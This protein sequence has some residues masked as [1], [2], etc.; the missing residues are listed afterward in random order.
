MDISKIPQLSGWRESPRFPLLYI[1]KNGRE[2]VWACWVKGNIVYRTDG[3]VDGKLKDPQ[4]HEYSGN[5]LRSGEEQA[6][7]EAEKLWLKQVDHD[8]APAKSDKA[9]RKIYDHVMEQKNQNGGMNRGV[10]LFTKSE[11][12]TKTTA[13]KKTGEQ[14]RPMLAKKYKD[15]INEDTF[16]LTNPGKAIKFPAIAQ[17]KVDGIRALPQICGDH[18]TLESRNGNSF[19]HLN[20]IRE[21]IKYWLTK[22]KGAMW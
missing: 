8:Y 5:S 10:K 15:W 20:H 22:K 9:G 21:G 14:H 17:A 19:V 11:I 6:P 3:F 7:L 12:T 18:V 16:T 4:A 2:R 1:S 13:G